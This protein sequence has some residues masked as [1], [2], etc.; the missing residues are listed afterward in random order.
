MSEPVTIPV[1]DTPSPTP[2]T[3][4]PGTQSTI[5]QKQ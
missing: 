4:T 1:P 2:A 5:P 3:G